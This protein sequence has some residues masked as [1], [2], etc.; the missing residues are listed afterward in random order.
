MSPTADE[1]K[2]MKERERLMRQQEKVQRQEQMRI[3]RE[4]RAQQIM[5]VG[6]ALLEAMHYYCSLIDASWA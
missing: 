6:D 1:V 4:M 2:K 5:E 3:E